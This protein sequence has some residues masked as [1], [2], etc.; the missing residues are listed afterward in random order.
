MRNPRQLLTAG[1]A[2]ALGTGL[3]LGVLVLLVG[4]HVSIPLATFIAALAGAVTNFTINK[5]VAFAV[6]GY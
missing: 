6:Y 5:Y 2:G 1:I 4:H 3:D